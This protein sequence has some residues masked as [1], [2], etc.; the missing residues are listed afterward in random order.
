MKLKEAYKPLYM[1]RTISIQGY[2]LHIP[3]GSTLSSINALHDEIF[4]HEFYKHDKCSIDPGDIVLDGGAHMGMASLYFML[5]GASK[6]IAVEPAPL[7]IDALVKNLS[8]MGISH[9]IVHKALWRAPDLDIR[10]LFMPTQ[11]CGSRIAIKSGN[12]LVPTTTID[13]LA[14]EGVNIIKLDIEGEELNAL[15]GAVNTIRNFKP[16][17]FISA[18][19]KARDIEI[20]PQFILNVEPAY[21]YEIVTHLEIL[22]IAYFWME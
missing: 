21:K 16:K 1:D 13:D 9:T 8:L 12:M 18:Y 19:H 5:H 3:Y 4:V 14:L 10:F 20:L 15:R 22:P 6:I 17:M 2:D 7:T 11:S